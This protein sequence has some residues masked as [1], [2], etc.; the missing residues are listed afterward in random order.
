MTNDTYKAITESLKAKILDCKTWLKGL[1]SS[2]SYKYITICYAQNLKKWAAA[3]L[4]DMTTLLMVDLYHIIGLGNMTAVQ[5]TSFLKLLKE[6]MAFR[7]QLKRIV[8][9][10]ETINDMPPEITSVQYTLKV[11]GKGKVLGT[12]EEELAGITDYGKD[13]GFELDESIT[14][15]IYSLIGK[16]VFLNEADVA[17]FCKYSRMLGGSE[18]V[19]AKMLAKMKNHGKYWGIRWST[20]CPGGVYQGKIESSILFMKMKS[21]YGYMKNRFTS[22]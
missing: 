5:Q 16:D 17:N 20:T 7:P 8:G 21:F 1:D 4:E 6:Y 9:H 22:K 12:G 19:E 11:L 10:L 18:A 15:P 3:E 2:E 14:A 13:S